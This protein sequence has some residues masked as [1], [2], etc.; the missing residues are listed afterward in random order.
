MIAKQRYHSQNT[1]GSTMNPISLANFTKANIGWLIRLL[2]SAIFSLSAIGKQMDRAAATVSMSWLFALPTDIAAIAVVVLSVFEIALVFLVWWQ[3]SARFILLVPVVFVGVLIYG[4]VRGIDCGCF[5][6][7]PFLSQLSFGAHLSLLA[8]MFLGLLYL[9]VP[10][11]PSSTESATSTPAGGKPHARPVS[12]NWL[13]WSG[14]AMMVLA[15]MTVPFSATDKTAAPAAGFPAVDR[16]I[17]QEVLATGSAVLIDA[18]SDYEYEIDHIDGAINIPYDSDSLAGL[19]EE[20]S[21]KRADLVLY[22]NG[23]HCDNAERLAA[24]LREL[25]CKR[26]RIYTGGWED[27]ILE[28]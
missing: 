5:G 23:P 8:G 17:V 24:R 22:C 26:I 15:F 20:L 2:L 1:N 4:Q 27:W 13:G 21:L 28:E 12:R 9:A 6:S 11:K 7:L 3:R 16:A 18:R 14:L 25:G 10:P 19:V